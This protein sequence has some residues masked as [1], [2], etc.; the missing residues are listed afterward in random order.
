MKMFKKIGFF[1]VTAASLF[2]FS[3]NTYAATYYYVYTS[4]GTAINVR[5]GPSTSYPIMTTVPSGSRQAFYCYKVGQTVTGLYGT[6]NIW[7]QVTVV[8]NGVANIGYI[9]D[10]YVK[11]GSD[12][13]VLIK[14]D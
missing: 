6:S 5:S 1:A 12:S 4:S 11:T 10:T 14:C 13:P 9:S 3:T 2:A 8:K 7:D